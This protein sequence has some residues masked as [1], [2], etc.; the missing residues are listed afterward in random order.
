MTDSAA[1]TALGGVVEIDWL[2]ILRRRSSR[3]GRRDW[4]VAVFGKDSLI[5]LGFADF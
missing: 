2:W 4:N 1:S 3:I 5:V